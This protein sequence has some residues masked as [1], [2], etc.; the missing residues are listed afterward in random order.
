ML[1]NELFEGV[2]GLVLVG[3]E[4]LGCDPGVAGDGF[5]D[6][7][8]VDVDVAGLW[9]AEEGGADDL[10]LVGLADEPPEAEGFDD[11]YF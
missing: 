5:G 1:F 6:W 4:V 3:E 8:G 11:V 2:V 10:V 7:V 9:R